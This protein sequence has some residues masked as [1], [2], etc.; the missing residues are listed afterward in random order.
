MSGGL[1]RIIFSLML[2]LG[3]ST[4]LAGCGQKGPLYLPQESS[5]EQDREENADEAS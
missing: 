5:E 2:V 3:S 4:L 1:A